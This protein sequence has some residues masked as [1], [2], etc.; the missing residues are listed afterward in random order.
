MIAALVIVGMVLLAWVAFEVWRAPVV[1]DRCE[2]PLQLCRCSTQN[3]GFDSSV[4]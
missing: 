2:M 1:C 4:N 3:S